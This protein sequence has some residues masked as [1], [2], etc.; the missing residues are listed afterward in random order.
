MDKLASVVGDV[1][2]VGP[3]VLVVVDDGWEEI[4][5]SEG[6]IVVVSD[7]CVSAVWSVALDPLRWGGRGW[8][9]G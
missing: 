3:G 1:A 6:V 9:L 2:I 7:T 4:L 5:L 8:G